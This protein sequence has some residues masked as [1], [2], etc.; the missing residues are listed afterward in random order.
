LLLRAD[1]Q[2]KITPKFKRNSNNGEKLIKGMNSPESFA[3]KCIPRQS[4]PEYAPEQ[5]RC[6]IFRALHTKSSN[7]PVKQLL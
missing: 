6:L 3:V 1:I 4:T 2:H 7:L 5:K